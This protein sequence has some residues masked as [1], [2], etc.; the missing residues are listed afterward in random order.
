MNNKLLIQTA[1][2]TV[3]ALG[4]SSTAHA[5]KTEEEIKATAKAQAIA[6]NEKCA[7]IIRAG[8]NDCPTSQHACAGL[9]D[10]NNDPE[11]FTWMPVGTCEKIAGA[12][13]ITVKEKKKT[14]KVAKK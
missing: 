8:L 13:V 7:G 10:E 3:V 2:S 1:L 12:H 11:E 4:L 5:I 9:A 6:K 14:K